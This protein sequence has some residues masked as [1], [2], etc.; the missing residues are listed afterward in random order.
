MAWSKDGKPI[1]NG[2]DYTIPAASATKSTLELTTVQS[3]V[4]KNGVYKCKVTF[5]D[6]GDHESEL[7]LYVQSATPSA[8]K[9]YSAPGAT[10]TLSCVFYG[11]LKTAT[12]QWF[13]G[14]SDTAISTDSSYTVTPGT[15]DG[16]KRTDKLVV[17]TVDALD[18]DSYKCEIKALSLSATQELHVISK[19]YIKSIY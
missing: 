5:K 16:N 18:S 2:A 12:S 10:V 7:T 9:S 3:K 14:T 1:V 6:V 19:E 11:N 17:K 4:E 8:S 15:L 13:K